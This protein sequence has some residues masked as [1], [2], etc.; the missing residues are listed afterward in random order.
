VKCNG[1]K[2]EVL[3]VLEK[4]NV[5]KLCSKKRIKTEKILNFSRVFNIFVKL[6]KE[7][8]QKFKVSEKIALNI[9]NIFS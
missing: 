5:R 7:N 3:H 9:F 4:G 1:A 6:F 8:F 2:N